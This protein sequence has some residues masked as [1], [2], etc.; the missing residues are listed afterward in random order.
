[1]LY[2]RTRPGAAV[3]S[4][5]YSEGLAVKTG[6]ELPSVNPDMVNQLGKNY[7]LTLPQRMM[8][9]GCTWSA[10]VRFLVDSQDVCNIEVTTDSCSGG[11]QLDATM[12]VPSADWGI[13]TGPL[14][15]TKQ[16]VSNITITDVNFMCADRPTPSVW[17]DPVP[18]DTP[19]CFPTNHTCQVVDD[20]DFDVITSAYVCPSHWIMWSTVRSSSS[21]CSFDDGLTGPPRPSFDVSSGVCRNAVVGVEYNF[22]WSG[23]TISRLNATITLAN[24]NTTQFTAPLSQRFSVSFAGNTSQSAVHNQSSSTSN[25]MVF[26]PSGNPG[27]SIF[28]CCY[29]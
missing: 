18:S 25:N 28:I 13:A 22:L 16:A 6:L 17:S 26:P 10:P 23:Q 20:C 14:V 7:L 11:T 9:G 1:M 3:E 2:S 29:F 19:L 15:L 8:T 12:Y 27:K 21:R 4:G 24:I 5:G